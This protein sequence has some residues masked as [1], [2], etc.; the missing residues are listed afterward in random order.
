MK[1]KRNFYGDGNGCGG[2]YMDIYIFQNTLTCTNKVV[3]LYWCKFYI[4]RYEQ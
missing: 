1:A 4:D 2:V 3:A